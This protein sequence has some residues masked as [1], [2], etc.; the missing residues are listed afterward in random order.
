MRRMDV[1]RTIDVSFTVLD[2][3]S[4]RTVS[5][6]LDGV[7][8]SVT[9]YPNH[10]IDW[11][12]SA[13]A[14]EIYDTVHEFATGAWTGTQWEETLGRAFWGWF[15]SD[16]LVHDRGTLTGR[17]ALGATG[18]DLGA[19]TFTESELEAGLPMVAVWSIW[20]DVNDDGR[21]DA[22]DVLAFRQWKHDR[23]LESFGMPVRFNTQLNLHAAD[24]NVDGVVDAWD[25]LAFNE[26]LHDRDFG[27]PFWPLRFG[28]ILG[29]PVP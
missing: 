14:Q 11:N 17:P 3:A 1:P 15:R 4:A 12:Q 18:E 27:F 13:E 29:R 10:P 2:P 28:T 9:A 24:V 25:I 5:F 26:W 23:V 8:T 7:G 20:G 21:V 6:Q 16:E 22:F 19:L